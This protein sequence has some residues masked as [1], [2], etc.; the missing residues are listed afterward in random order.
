MKTKHAPNQSSATAVLHG[1]KVWITRFGRRI[2]PTFGDISFEHID[3]DEDTGCYKPS[4][5]SNLLAEM[6]RTKVPRRYIRFGR[7]TGRNRTSANSITVSKST[8][9]LVRTIN[10]LGC[11]NHGRDKYPA[12]LQR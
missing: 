10:K 11:D 12:V 6:K 2:E 8:D 7:V 4:F 5:G 1:T 3:L 9:C